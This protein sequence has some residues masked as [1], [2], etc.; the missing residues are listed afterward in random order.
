MSWARFNLVPPLPLADVVVGGGVAIFRR[1]I[2]GCE[3]KILRKYGE[4]AT[5]PFSLFEIDGINLRVDAV[6]ASG[7]V[8]ITK[9]EAAETNITTGF[10]DEGS[11]YSIPLS[12]TEMEAA[13]ITMVLIDQTGPKA[14][15]DRIITIETYG[16]A[17]AQHAFDLDTALVTLAATTHAGAVIPTVTNLSNLPAITA[18]WLTA[19]GIAASALDGKGDWN[20]GKTAYALSQSF[21]ANFADLA[22]TPTTGRVDVNANNDKTGY[23][24]T[25]LAT[26]VITAA[27]I[28]A[29]ALTG[30]GNWNVD[31]T[32]YSISATGLDLILQGSDFG[33]AMADAIW[34]EILTGATH[35]ITNSA[36]KRV[37]DV[38]DSVVIYTDTAVSATVN[39]ITLPVGASAVDGTY[40]PADITIVGGTG[41]GQ[42]RLILQYAGATKTA[43]VDR[44]WKTIPDGTSAFAITTNAGREHVNEGLAQAGGT[45]TITLNTLASGITDVYV[46]QIVFIRSGTGDD[47]SG[48]VIAYNGTTKIATIHKNWGVQPDGTSAYV[49]LPASPVEVTDNAVTAIQTGLAT[50]A[51]LAITDGVVDDIK[52]ETLLIVGD[53]NELQTDWTDGGRLDTLLDAIPTD[54]MRGTD[55]AA[56]ASVATEARMSE[57]DEATAGK[58]ANQTDLIK[59]VVDA[60]TA[61]LGVAGAGLNDVGGM[62]DGMKAEVLTEVIKLLTTQMTESYAAN[63]VAPTLAQ[64]Q[65]AKHQ[66]LMQFGAA[67]TSITV[68]QLDDTTTAFIVTLDDATTP[69]DAKRV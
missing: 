57:L 56:L 18:N 20:I 9:D 29:N 59:T 48:T 60:L 37:R 67:G 13:R 23:G 53:T 10:T 8:K 45:N 35:N 33:L 25:S 26:D 55:D 40:D 11:A 52:A 47:Q 19:T 4:S 39:S 16:H 2:E 6:Y 17:S 36:G 27:S 28:Q 3:M 69:T 66:M 65:F 22:V 46:G 21:P 34:D 62:S 44:N 24:V 31:K 41:V 51:A 1:R 7:D 63:G 30:K 64:A 61:T 49:M 15:L 32:G 12:A 5:I 38:I 68:R 50:S 42:S 58:L 54:P 14:W 43:I